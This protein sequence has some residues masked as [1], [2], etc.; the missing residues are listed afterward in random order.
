MK[1]ESLAR[2]WPWMRLGLTVFWLI[3]ALAL[4]LERRVRAAEPSEP[5]RQIYS[6]VEGW[7]YRWGDPV[8]QGQRVEEW[9]TG[10]E[11]KSVGWKPMERFP[12]QIPGRNGERNLWQRVVLPQTPIINPS[13]FVLGVDQAMEV[14]LDS[15]K[16]YSFGDIDEKGSGRFSGYPWHAI[17]LPK[18]YAGHTLSFRIWADHVNIGLVGDVSIGHEGKYLEQM[19]R[20]NTNPIIVVVIIA[21]IGIVCLVM[22]GAKPG[23]REYLALGGFSLMVGLYMLTRLPIKEV[24]Y[25]NGLFWSYVELSTFYFAVTSFVATVDALLVHSLFNILRWC[26]ITFAVAAVVLLLLAGF[27]AVSLFGTLMPFQILTLIGI[28]ILLTAI[29]RRMIKGDREASIMIAGLVLVIV[30]T[31][32]DILI[33]IGVI[34]SSWQGA[35]AFVPWGVLGLI[36]CFGYILIG[37]FLEV[38][39]RVL[40]HKKNLEML[41]EEGRKIGATATFEALCSQVKTSF[42]VVAGPAIE[43]SLH[44]HRRVFVDRNLAD[45]F[46]SFTNG[47]ELAAPRQIEDVRANGNEVL[48]VE[49]PRTQEPLAAVPLR[50]SHDEA[51]K[52]ALA[53]LSEEEC[54][55]EERR[56][57]ERVVTLLE[58]MTN[59][60][61]SAITTVRL[62]KTFGILEKRTQEIRTVF[63]NINQGILMVDETLRILPEYSAHLETLFGTTDVAERDFMEFAFAGATLSRDTL[64]QIENCLRGSL[65]EDVLNWETNADVLPK[66]FHL[67]RNGAELDYEVDWTAIVGSDDQVRR[68]M[69][70][71]RDVTT[72]KALKAA[73]EANRVEME[74]IS[75]IVAISPEKFDGFLSTGRRYVSECLSLLNKS[76]GASSEDLNEIKRYLHTV[77]GNSRTLKLS[78]LTTL[79]H[80]VESILIELMQQNVSG[81]ALPTARLLEEVGKVGARIED[82]G[83]IANERLG[84]KEGRNADL[85][86]AIDEAITVSRRAAGEAE[87]NTNLRQQMQSLYCRLVRLSRPTLQNLVHTLG[88]AIGNLADELKRPRPRVEVRGESDWVL[89]IELAEA[90]QGSLTHLF[91]NSVDHGFR[92]VRD[93]VI[94][95]TPSGSAAAPCLEYADNGSGL[96]LERLKAVGRARGVLV[97]ENPSDEQIAN[98]VFV[99]GISTAEVVTDVSGRGVGMDAVKSLMGRVGATVDLVF[100]GARTEQ[101]DRPFK[102]VISIRPQDIKDVIAKE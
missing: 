39:R 58:P 34:L 89:S 83:R 75:Q 44:F 26:W 41:A 74:M 7:E 45:G 97:E 36:F 98:L 50:L 65:G 101:G 87:V 43:P 15:T 53:K 16:I 48:M 17:P 11:S 100:I 18:D 32:L 52:R 5:A 9:L 76:G 99:S 72:L 6:I 28:V 63:A 61:A 2:Q 25:P 12:G 86:A 30:A 91:R 82:Y 55:A 13:L 88:D 66:E 57:L 69:V 94:S 85:M 27:G 70:T 60:M 38:Y 64:S 77:K 81:G 68:L 79:T 33:S 29:I 22:F 31:G 80:D 46:Y 67:V 21:F 1:S 59:N 14:Y 96:H 78:Y 92:G 51:Q 49:D 73:A 19:I 95:L 54:R 24:L 4:L 84:R 3:M 40:E 56:M 23:N 93:G 42:A 8:P 62:E 47:D 10:P 35:L 102:L 37:R 90:L 71:F 20:K